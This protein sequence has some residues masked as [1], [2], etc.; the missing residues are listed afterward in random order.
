MK[1]YFTYKN[2]YKF[3]AVG[4]FTVILSSCGTS[5]DRM[6]QANDGIYGSSG[7]AAVTQEQEQEVD[8]RNY[9]KQYFQTKAQVY[10]NEPEGDI[11]FTDVEG[12][13]SINAYIDEDGFIH[14]EEIHYD[15]SYGPWGE[16]SEITINVYNNPGWAGYG[17]WHRP[18]W[19]HR[20][21]WGVSYWH[22]WGGFYGP[23]WGWG[24]AHT[25]YWGGWGYPFYAH[26]GY[27]YNPYYGGYS[28]YVAYNRGRRNT[29]YNPNRSSTRAASRENITR[30]GRSND[31]RYSRSEVERRINNSRNTQNQNVRE[32]TR[33]VPVRAVPQGNQRQQG[34][35]RQQGIINNRRT[36][37]TPSTTPNTTRQNTTPQ[38]PPSI[39][40]GGGTNNVRSS[41]G[42]GV[43][44][45]G[46]VR[47]G[48]GRG[49]RG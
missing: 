44:S 23:S 15:E 29:D 21:G 43:R 11:I 13:T 2:I 35:E 12:Y 34:N 1:S 8:N 7:V 45:G 20:S 47:S 37:P 3:I 39:N 19:W 9:Y 25:Y 26:P 40:R 14:E 30:T 33:R 10:A 18:I 16:T 46:A 42:T 36:N 49:G 28:N 38:N 4:I 24:W 32:T 41:G 22:P 27:Y 48:G 31:G 5:R 6:N 17:Y